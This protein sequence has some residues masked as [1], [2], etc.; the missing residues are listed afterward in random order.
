MAGEIQ[1]MFVT[2]TLGL[3]LIKAGK[4]ARSAT[5]STARASFLP[6]VPTL[7]EGGAP[8]TQMDASWQGFSRRRTYLVQ[9]WRDSIAMRT[10]RLP[11]RRCASEF[12]LGLNPIGA[13]PRNFGH[14]SPCDQ[15]HER[16][17][18]PGGIEPE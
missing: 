4:L 14:S 16:G 1:V 13:R 5:D 17:C 2:P 12:K 10:R 7:A 3:P 6:E 18:A 8:L 11:C 9:S 15:A